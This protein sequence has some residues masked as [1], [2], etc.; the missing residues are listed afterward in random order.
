M[1][2]AFSNTESFKRVLL[3]HSIVFLWTQELQDSSDK[4]KNEIV[5]AVENGV[6]IYDPNR[7]AALCTDWSKTG[8]RFMLM[9]KTCI[10][11]VIAPICCPE[12]WT[13]VY[14]GSRFTSPAGS[15]YA[16]VEGECLAAA[17]ALEKT[18]HFTLGAPSLYLAVDHK[19]L[20]K[21]VGD[22]GLQDIE[23][24][25]QQNLKKKPQIQV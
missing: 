25:R 1:A 15:T 17:W 20:L 18:K 14:V 7:V 10:C 5:K 24:P 4:S 21:I 2:Y 3:K 6:K 11:E 8:I 9:Q 23:N 13:L 22:K 12:G 19:P 16:P